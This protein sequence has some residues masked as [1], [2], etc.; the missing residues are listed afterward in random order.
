MKRKTSFVCRRQQCLFCRTEKPL[1]KVKYCGICGSDIHVL[2]G[3]HPTARFPVIPGHEFVGE[4]VDIK[5]SG[6]QR[7]EI[8]DYV[9]AQPFFSCGNC[10]PCANGEDNGL[11]RS[12]I[13]GRS[14]RRRIRPVRQSIDPEDVP[15]SEGH[16]SAA[17]SADRAGCCGCTR[18]EKK[19][20]A[21]GRDG[22]DHRR[23]PHRHAHRNDRPPRR[24]QAGGHF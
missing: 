9:V 3:E 22:A 4:L 7:Y 17:G 5:G 21:G 10:E 16:G 19:R 15:D 14:R 18:R 1:I 8:G 6:S 23:R 12:A 20:P 13:Y 11:R 24:S 2:R